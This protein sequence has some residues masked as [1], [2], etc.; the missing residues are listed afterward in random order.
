LSFLVRH[1]TAGDVDT[2]TGILLSKAK[3]SAQ[4]NLSSMLG[5]L[6]L[7]PT[8]RPSDSGSKLMIKKEGIVVPLESTLEIKTRV[9]HKP[10]EFQEIAPQVWV[11]QTPKLVRAYHQKGTFQSP[12]VE[13]VA[14]GIK[15]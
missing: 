6:S 8:D 3:Q 12:V 15:S 10:F 1:E 13:D 14:A 9:S 5:V 4:G 11:S 7:S 2:G